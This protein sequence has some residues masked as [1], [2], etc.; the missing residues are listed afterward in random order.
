MDGINLFNQFLALH[1]PQLLAS[2]VPQHLWPALYH[3]ITTE[4]FDA[5]EVLQLLLIEYDD[6]E[7]VSEEEINTRPSFASY[8]SRDEGLRA[9][10]V[11]NIFLIDH[12][13][14]FRLNQVR[15][16]LED[17][18]H[19]CD[20]ICVIT[21]VDLED[22]DRINKVMKKMWKYCNPYSLASNQLSE[23]DR[24][25]IWY[26]MDEVGSA[27]GHSDEPNFRLVPFLHL[28]SQT[29]F[30]L[31]FPIKDVECGD[32]VMTDYVEYVN[33][34]A[35]ERKVLLLPWKHLDLSKESFLQCEPSNEYFLAG[36]IPENY[37]T[38]DES[39]P[40]PHINRN[41]PLKVYSEYGLVTQYLNSPCFTHV[42]DRESAD[43]LWLTTH[44]KNFT[45]LSLETPNKF[46]NQFPLEYIVTVKDLL[47]I[48]CRRAAVEHHNKETLDTYPLWLPT[49]YNLKTELLQF[50]SYYQNRANKKL[51]N[52]WI[53]KPWNL[54]RGLDT[55]ITGHLAQILRLPT[56]GPKIAQ[57]Y[58]ENP[59]LFYRSSLDAKVKFDIRYVILVKSVRPL[60]AFVH[61]KFYLRFSNKPFSLD[62][63]DD[64]EKHFTVMNYVENIDLH[65]VKCEEFLDLWRDQYP[66]N[67]WSEIEDH[68]CSVLYEMLEC[69][70][71]GSAPT[72]IQPCSQS[73]ALYAAD[74]M[75]AW[76]PSASNPKD[77][78]IQP[79][80]LEVNWTPDC[81][82]ACEYYP[83]FYNDI[84]KLLF[85]NECNDE[86]FRLLQ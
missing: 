45:Q 38:E 22:D 55:H 29:T 11:N 16:Q 9:N 52:H 12:C 58:I 24:Q 34:G 20:R 71:K 72:A 67:D 6:E 15:Q 28:N 64:Y 37:V 70:T 17:Y 26:I 81:K 36:H 2:G 5:G 41:E 14:T 19:L 8:V 63:F 83:E 73:R 59:V 51:D 48:I 40:K 82:R 62:H 1:T 21:G 76:Q 57:K 39:L 3:K 75:L 86:V 65:H 60:E 44:F 33:K 66:E 27:V 25:P 68:I 69:A 43:I 47:S 23:E 31:L 53:I 46:V 84:F 49:T 35:D 79:K 54:A 7:D 42:D 32:Q 30:S 77:L 56:T 85:L 78:K 13:W 61:R 18:E 4:T 74:I 50:A 10:D 80:L